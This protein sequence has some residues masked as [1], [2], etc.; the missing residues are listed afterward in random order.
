MTKNVAK[1]GVFA[2][3]ML[4]VLGMLILVLGQIRLDSRTP[5][6]ADFGDASGLKEGQ[7]VRLAG[8]DVGR[9]RSVKL[10][11]RTAHVDFDVADSVRIT[12]DATLQVRYQNLLGDRYLEVVNGPNIAEPM[13][14]DGSFP[15]T[16]TKSALDID[17]LLGGLAPLTRSLEPE[18]VDRLSGELL[19]VL[20]GQGGTITGILQQVAALTSRLADRDQLIGAVIANLGTTLQTVGDDSQAL[21]NIIDQLQQLVTTLSQR[22]TPI[23][24]AL[25]RINSGTATVADLLLDDRPAIRADVAEI[26]RAATVL[27]DGSAQIEAVLT[28]LPDAYQR[29]SRLGA[30]GSFFNFYLCAVTLKVDGP[31]GTPIIT[32][33]VQQKQGRCV[34]PQ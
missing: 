18:Q 25:V 28:E 27:D 33:L 31:G 3:A 13:P 30:Y 7:V 34:T 24:D 5:Y 19:R 26:N 11:N 1:F 9:V 14:E 12:K 29:L 4:L 17:A 21:S 22:S 10:E 16:Q 2:L 8:V 6:Q 32:K 20:Q 15:A 23:A